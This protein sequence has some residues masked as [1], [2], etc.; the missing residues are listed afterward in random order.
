M[1]KGH[2]TSTRN[3][4]YLSI[5][6]SIK[7]SGKLPDLHIKKSLLSFYVCRLKKA[8]KI[9]RIG[10]ATWIILPEKTST[11][12]TRGLPPTLPP[13]VVKSDWV[14]LHNLVLI[15]RVNRN[16][17][18]LLNR[19]SIKFSVLSSGVYRIVYEGFKIWLCQDR[20]VVY[21]KP[22]VDFLAFNPAESLKLCLE[23][24]RVFVA[25]LEDFLGCSLRSSEGLIEWGINRKHISLVRNALA[26]HFNSNKIRVLV[27]DHKGYWLMIDNSFNLG[28]LELIRSS[29]NTGESKVIQDWFNDYKANPIKSSEIIKG[30]TQIGANF[31]LIQ[32]NLDKVTEA[33]KRLG[34]NI[35]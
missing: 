32:A 30:F 15:I 12:N 21:V 18:A 17:L 11:S 20:L 22:S 33:L 35:D 19:N 29:T 16:W 9:K 23:W 24:F 6:E 1:K 25:S 14:R 28:E 7:E 26:Q 2:K 3:N 4:L 8:G 5:L 10:Y 27:S 31:I 34:G 13:L